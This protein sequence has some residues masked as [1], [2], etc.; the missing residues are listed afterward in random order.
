MTD[1]DYLPAI[2]AAMKAEGCE[3][4]EYDGGGPEYGDGVG[5]EAHENTDWDT[6][7]DVCSAVA[8]I[9]EASA[10]FV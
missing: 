8:D 10:P 4:F 6:D 9:V 2:R 3:R 5:C 1:P 7:R